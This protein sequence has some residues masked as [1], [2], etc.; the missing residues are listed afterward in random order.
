[1]YKSI[2][3]IISRSQVSILLKSLCEYLL[4]ICTFSLFCTV[5]VVKQYFLITFEYI[6]SFEY[7]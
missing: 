7:N 2:L 6:I 3:H 5:S 4:T 1:M